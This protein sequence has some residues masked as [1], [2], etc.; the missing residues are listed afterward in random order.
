MWKPLPSRCVACAVTNGIG[1]KTPGYVP[2]K[3]AVPQ[4]GWIWW[5][6]SLKGVD[7]VE[8][9]PQRRWIWWGPISI[10]ESNEC[11]FSPEEG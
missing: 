2:S 5:N 4:R 8:V 1:V 7:L 3:E 6:S 9:V 11:S 10:G